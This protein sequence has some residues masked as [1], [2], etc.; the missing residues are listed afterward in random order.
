MKPIILNNN[1]INILLED[2]AYASNP[3]I[4]RIVALG[5]LEKPFSLSG[6]EIGFL[7]VELLKLTQKCLGGLLGIGIDQTSR[8]E[9]GFQKVIRKEHDKI[10][11]LEGFAT[12]LPNEPVSV[13][14]AKIREATEYTSNNVGFYLVRKDKNQLLA[15]FSDRGHH[16]FR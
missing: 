14:N 7:R 4:L 9:R 5:I 3:D 10:I 13:I 8:I 6:Q 11:R 2:L 12:L 1:F 15:K 16:A